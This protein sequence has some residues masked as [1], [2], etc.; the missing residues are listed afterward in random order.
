MVF[1]RLAFPRA[2]VV[3]ASLVCVSAAHAQTWREVKTAN[4]TVV[5]DA[6]EGRARNIAWQFEQMRAAMRE[7]L[8]WVQVQLDRPVTIIAVKDENSMRA[9]APQYWEGRGMRP[10]SVSVGGIDRH[11]IALRADAEV[12]QQLMNPHNAAYRSYS[13]MTLGQSLDRTIPLW[14]GEGLSVILSNSIV[15]QREV[16]FGRPMPWTL[17]TIKEGPRMPLPELFGIQR[18][19]PSYRSSIGRERFDAQAW[20]LVHFMIF[21]NKDNGPARFDQMISA[22]A[23]GATTIEAVNLAYGSVD[24]LD[25]A[26][27]LYV[28]QGV[29]SYS[30]LPTS[31]AIVESKLPVRVMTVPEHALSRA[32]FHAAMGRPVEARAVAATARKAD[33]A[34]SVVDDV[35]GLLFDRDEQ[36]DQAIEAFTRAAAA[37]SANFWTYYRLAGLKA[38]AG[39]GADTA[40]EIEPLLVRATTL[41]PTYASAHA[42][43][44]VAH[45][46]R[47]QLEPAIA[48]A[49]RAVELEPFDLTQRLMLIRLLMNAR[50]ADEAVKV[51]QETMP[52]ARTPQQREALQ[53]VLG[54][55]PR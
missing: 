40:G 5:S 37:N 2:V 42:L 28:S 39:I 17:E 44:S 36:A 6:S 4:F 15:R 43:L 51:A 13:A 18:N 32:S 41:E 10:V 3:V 24:A 20:S 21:G 48:S 50:Q 14:L 8:P 29:F 45:A 53:A 25:A 54:A 22:L 12:E 26:Y 11:Y 23:G 31:T 9:I 47:G 30:T 35:E 19:T 38:R 16:V 1:T 49:R 46:N 52:Y 27:K 7:G 33:P 34:S 55:T